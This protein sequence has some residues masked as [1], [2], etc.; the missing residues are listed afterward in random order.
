MAVNRVAE[1]LLLRAAEGRQR[2]GDGQREPAAVEAR[3]EFGSELPRERQPSLDPERLAP[4]EL[5]DGG[6]GEPVVVAKRGRHARLVHGAGSLVGRVGGK[7]RRLHRGGAPSR[8]DDDRDLRVPFGTPGGQTLEAV[9][10]LEDVPGSRYAKR[11]GP[12]RRVRVAP[13]PAQRGE[14]GPNPVDRD[15]KNQAHRA[16]STGRIWKSGYRYAMNPLETR[17]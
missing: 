17:P 15:V 9:E 11:E 4:E 3:G 7:E 1:P 14:R 8:L 13:L 6:L 5:R 10:D 12:E 2:Q 16:S